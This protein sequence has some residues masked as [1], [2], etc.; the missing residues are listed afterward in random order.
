MRD[1]LFAEMNSRKMKQKDFASLIEISPAALSR[2]F[3]EEIDLAFQTMTN[4]IQKLFPETEKDVMKKYIKSLKLQD[5]RHALEYCYMNGEFS[6]FETKLKELTKSGNPTDREWVEVYTVVNDR[7]KG[8]LSPKEVVSASKKLNVSSVEMIFMK[9]LLEISGYYDLKK[10]EYIMDELEDAE[11]YLPLIKNEYI[12]SSYELRLG[13]I[14]AHVSLRC[15]QVERSRT[16]CHMLIEKSNH[17]LLTASIYHT[18][19]HSYIFES[20]DQASDNLYKALEMYIKLGKEAHIDSCK[21][22]IAFVMNY[23]GLFP[24]TLDFDRMDIE[25]QHEIIHCYI[26]QGKFTLAREMLLEIDLSNLSNTS[27][28]YHYFYRGLA[29]EER[30]YFF[31]SIYCF[32]KERESFFAELPRE[33]LRRRGESESVLKATLGRE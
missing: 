20:Y 31:E 24:V 26:R 21:R 16:Y 15:N 11:Q 25:S 1:V 18:L 12:K 28:G 33:E 8:R 9:K 29:F 6:I 19:G 17:P 7:R 3:K 14:I 13:Q 23:Y 32:N 2:Y 4:V 27:L 5:A 10:Y 22:S 30:N